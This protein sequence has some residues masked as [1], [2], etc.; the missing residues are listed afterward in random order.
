MAEKV[1]IAVVNP[2]TFKLI[3]DKVIELND[4]VVDIALEQQNKKITLA[5]GQKTAGVLIYTFDGESLH[6]SKVLAII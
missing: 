1:S 2:L 5:I 6:F 4:T 3:K